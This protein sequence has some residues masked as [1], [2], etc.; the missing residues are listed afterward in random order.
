MI[1]N[2][3]GT[4]LRHAEQEARRAREQLAPAEV[5]LGKAFIFHAILHTTAVLWPNGRWSLEHTTV[6]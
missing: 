6:V 1:E 2:H 4:A 5:Y 3:G